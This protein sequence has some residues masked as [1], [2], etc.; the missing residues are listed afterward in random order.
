MSTIGASVSL[1]SVGTIPSIT[2][3]ASDVFILLAVS[4]CS[5]YLS[6]ANSSKTRF[7]DLLQELPSGSYQMYQNVHQNRTHGRVHVR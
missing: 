4:G 1:F 2:E 7:E 3:S 6:K 5:L